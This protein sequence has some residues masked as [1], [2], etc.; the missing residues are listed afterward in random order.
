MNKNKNHAYFSDVSVSDM[1]DEDG[2]GGSSKSNSITSEHSLQSTG[3]SASSQGSS[4][5][6]LPKGQ[7]GV[8][9]QPGGG[10]LH[11]GDVRGAGSGTG[12]GGLQNIQGGLAAMNIGDRE[13]A[14]IA[15]QSQ[16]DNLGHHL[17]HHAVP[18]STPQ[19]FHRTTLS[20]PQGGPSP[21]LSAK[22]KL[23]QVCTFDEIFYI[24]RFAINHVKK[25][26]R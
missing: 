7:G 11:R 20:Q 17:H 5:N 14:L 23:S 3:I 6:S 13:A 16:Y 2:A 12:S 9:L 18:S 8:P 26:T 24:F 25:K 22:S 19:G 15:A 10:D 1:N 4:T 21:S